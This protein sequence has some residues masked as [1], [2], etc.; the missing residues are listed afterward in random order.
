MKG[1]L[2]GGGEGGGEGGAGVSVGRRACQPIS[3]THIHTLFFYRVHTNLHY[4][5]CI[6]FSACFLFLF[7]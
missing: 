1:E 7:Q 4:F 3:H 2:E 5:A 6:E